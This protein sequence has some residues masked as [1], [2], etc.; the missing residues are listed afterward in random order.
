MVAAA[1]WWRLVDRDPFCARQIA[2]GVEEISRFQVQ[3][4]REAIVCSATRAA[5][6]SVV[7]VHRV[8]RVS[9]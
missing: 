1:E 2:F 3:R 4:D 6:S 9:G 8:F 7:S 5:L